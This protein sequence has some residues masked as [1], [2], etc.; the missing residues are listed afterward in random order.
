MLIDQAR[1]RNSRVLSGVFLFFDLAFFGANFAKNLHGGRFP[2]P[3]ALVLLSRG[4]K[5]A[6]QQ[7][8]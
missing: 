1:T 6:K 4:E 5:P 2:L 3:I 8:Q 7:A